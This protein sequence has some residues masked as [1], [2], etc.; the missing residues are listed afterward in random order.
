V[1]IDFLSKFVLFSF[2]NFISFLFVSVLFLKKKKKKKICLVFLS[3]LKDLGNS[4]SV[5]AIEC[6]LLSL[7]HTYGFCCIVYVP[8]LDNSSIAHEHTS[9]L[10]SSAIIRR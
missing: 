2:C 1:E 3:L 7:D 8:V 5:R 4:V 9:D 10:R 6:R